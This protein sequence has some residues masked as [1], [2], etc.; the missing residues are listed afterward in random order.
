MFIQKSVLKKGRYIFHV[1]YKNWY[2]KDLFYLNDQK[3]LIPECVYKA[4]QKDYRPVMTH[5]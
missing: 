2:M 4:F 1:T 3:H 5:I